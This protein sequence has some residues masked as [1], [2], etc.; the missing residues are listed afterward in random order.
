[1]TN[2]ANPTGPGAGTGTIPLGDSQQRPSPAPT[3]TARRVPQDTLAS[4]NGGH[5]D[6]GCSF[7]LMGY[8]MA[9][10]KEAARIHAR[11]QR[12]ETVVT[13]LALVVYD[14]RPR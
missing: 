11:A 12:H 6:R 10:V 2:P 4:C 3:A 9:H 5:D 8:D 13:E 14:G 7:T 1:M